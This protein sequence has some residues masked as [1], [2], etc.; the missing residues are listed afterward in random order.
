MDPA[1]APGRIGAQHLELQV[2][3]E[4]A[5]PT[6]EAFTSAAGLKVFKRSDITAPMSSSCNIL[7]ELSCNL[8]L[9]GQL[10]H[11]GFLTA[12]LGC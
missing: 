4:N 7:V 3:I 12:E 1:A 6:G 10:L 9:C 2:G 5:L 8:S 11:V